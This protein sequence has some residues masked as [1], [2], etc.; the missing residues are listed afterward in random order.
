[1]FIMDKRLQKKCSAKFVF[2]NHN[3]CLSCWRTS[4][5]GPV[6][7]DATVINETPGQTK[8]SC[9]RELTEFLH[10][11]LSRGRVVKAASKLGAVPH[12]KLLVCRNGLDGV[13]I[14][15]HPVLAGGK[16]LLLLGMSWVH[17]THP[18]TL[19]LVQ[20]VHKMTEL[21]I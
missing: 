21:S 6:L 7:C 12:Q 19:L 11:N 15:A 3:L 16:V 5:S 4:L 9:L 1:M 13:E 10:H 18:V 20:S 8:R 2:R 17:I 14:D